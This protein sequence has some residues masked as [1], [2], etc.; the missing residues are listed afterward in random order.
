MARPRACGCGGRVGGAGIVAAWRAPA[1]GLP[2]TGHPSLRQNLM[3]KLHSTA[4]MLA[5]A[6][7]LAACAS[8]A[9]P[10]PSGGATVAAIAAA[11][12]QPTSGNRASG[13][14]WFAQEGDHLVVR[15]RVG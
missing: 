11:K 10:R 6:G 3:A 8:P 13:T 14:V 2:A 7:L 9:P 15:G 5:A 4:A 12:L 1:C